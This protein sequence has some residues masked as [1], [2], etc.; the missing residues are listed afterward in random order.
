MNQ[1]SRLPVYLAIDV[2][3]SMNHLI[4]GVNESLA[5]VFD[6]WAAD[7]LVAHKLAVCVVSF[8]DIPHIERPLSTIAENAD[9]PALS[10]R[11]GTR[12]RE[13]FDLLKSQI[14][15]DIGDLKGRGFS[16]FRPTIFF[17]TDGNPTDTGWQQALHELTNDEYRYHPNIVAVGT[18][19]VDPRIIQRIATKP[20]FA[21]L[22]LLDSNPLEASSSFLIELGKSVARSTSSV[23]QGKTELRLNLPDNFVTVDVAE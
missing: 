2:S 9:A 3:Y 5:G 11:D 15:V 8:S 7:P 13:A 16:V 20:D 21:F 14:E 23:G 10:V 6:R 18:G 17:F 22:A 1:L 12:Y 19:S 4:D